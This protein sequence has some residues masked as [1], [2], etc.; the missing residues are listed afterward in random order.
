MHRD[1]SHG[2]ALERTN[3]W[4]VLHRGVVGRLLC[5]DCAP[6]KRYRRMPQGKLRSIGILLER[7]CDSREEGW[8]LSASGAIG[9]GFRCG[10]ASSGSGKG[11]EAIV[12]PRMAGAAS[13]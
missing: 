7:A 12:G 9:Y 10:S 4:R 11:R 6:E 1:E 13:C 2:S 8:R 5:P 3:D